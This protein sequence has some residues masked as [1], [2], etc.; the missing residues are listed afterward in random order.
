MTVIVYVVVMYL[1]FYLAVFDCYL[2]LKVT[3]VP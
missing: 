1:D 3:G 2:K